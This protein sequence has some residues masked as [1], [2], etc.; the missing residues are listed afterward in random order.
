MPRPE[1]PHSQKERVETIHQEKTEFEANSFQEALST[2]INLAEESLAQ[3]R[4]QHSEG[5][6]I[7]IDENRSRIS[8]EPEEQSS[9]EFE[10]FAKGD[11]PHTTILDTGVAW[12][13][14]NPIEEAIEVVPEVEN[15][16]IGLTTGSIGV[17]YTDSGEQPEIIVEK[18]LYE[19]RN[20]VDSHEE[21]VLKSEKTRRKTREDAI[22]PYWPHIR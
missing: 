20:L 17:E 22:A 2:V 3:H 6:E 4:T 7:E 13:G 10:Y 9:L 8:L 11:P 18:L 12:I 15:C 5:F 21:L 1:I 16:S 14:R 19:L